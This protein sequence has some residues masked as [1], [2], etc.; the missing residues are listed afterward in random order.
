MYCLIV[1]QFSQKFNSSLK[2]G[3]FGMLHHVGL[4]TTGI[5]E[6]LKVSIITVTRIDELGT[7]AVTTNRHMLRRNT[8]SHT[9]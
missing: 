1:L 4:V 9:A 5:S 6:G 8:K 7:L 2:N 3:V